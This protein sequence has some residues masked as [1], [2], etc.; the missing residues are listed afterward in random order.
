MSPHAG[1]I[2]R[3]QRTTWGL[4]CRG[5]VTQPEPVSTL[6]ARLRSIELKPGTLLVARTSDDPKN[7]DSHCEALLV[8][9]LSSEPAERLLSLGTV[10]VYS[11]LCPCPACAR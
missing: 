11:F 2:T 1:A 4:P 7:T 9:R 3:E 10:L 8:D 5:N 6:L